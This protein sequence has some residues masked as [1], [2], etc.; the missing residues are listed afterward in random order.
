MNVEYI[1]ESDITIRAVDKPFVQRQALGVFSTAEDAYH[2]I[3][4]YIAD[5]KA[6]HTYFSRSHLCPKSELEEHILHGKMVGLNVV[7]GQFED[8]IYITK[9]DA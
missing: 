8:M 1:V 5:T 2:F 4:K 7:L 9:M 6:L 3:E